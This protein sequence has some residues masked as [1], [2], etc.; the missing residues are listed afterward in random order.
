MLIPIE[1]LFIEK[2][3][4]LSSLRS[5]QSLGLRE[6]VAYVKGMIAAEEIMLT[7]QAYVGAALLFDLGATAVTSFGGWVSGLAYDYYT[8]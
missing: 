5:C 3:E 2:S 1:C 8:K 4:A 7:S 6:G